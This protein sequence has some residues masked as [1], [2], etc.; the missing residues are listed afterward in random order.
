MRLDWLARGLD[1]VPAADD[2]LGPF[3]AARLA[4]MRFPKRR[5]EYRLRRWAGKTS[6]AAML[7]LPLDVAT[8]SRVEVRT[9]PGGAPVAYVDGRP[10]QVF[11]SLTDRAGWAVSTATT[12]PG[13][14]GCDMELVEPR[15]PAF[16]ADW[17]T[18]AEQDVVNAVV[19][20]DRDALANLMW[21]AKESALKVLKT[22]LRRDTRSVAVILD[23]DPGPDWRRL[24]VQ[25]IEGPVFPGW[26][27]RA[28]AY[29][30]S[31]VA[32]RDFAPPTCLDDPPRLAT[33]RPREAPI[34]PPLPLP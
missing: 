8:L 10:A 26:W 34:G 31:V 6:V 1:D 20:A 2:W 3:E 33:A 22:G 28:G 17:L 23:E 14:F 29:V 11:V 25:S 9:A 30:L 12:E 24:R 5:A 13:A 21:S 18:P 27:C 7:G 4:R 32:D 16:I 15:S 19:G